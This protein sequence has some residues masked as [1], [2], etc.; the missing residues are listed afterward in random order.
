VTFDP[1]IAFIELEI[2][3]IGRSPTPGPDMSFVMGM[4]EIAQF[5][6]L[7]DKP[8]ADR[9]RDEVE[10]KHADRVEQLRKAA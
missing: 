7:F 8:A 1:A 3:K 10:R 6:E 9:Y 5:V 4:I 2:A